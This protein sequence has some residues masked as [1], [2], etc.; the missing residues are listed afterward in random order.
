MLIC[1]V[2]LSCVSV[3]LMYYFSGKTETKAEYYFLADSNKILAVLT[4]I[5]AFVYFINLK[6]EYSKFINTVSMT[7]FGVLLIHANSDTMRKWLWKD[8]LN[9][10]GQYGSD[11]LYL[12]AILSVFAIFVV[13]SLIDFLRIK[14][15]EEPVFKIIN[16]KLSD[17]K[18][19]AEN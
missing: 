1:S 19:T 16:K 17:K 3:F 18:I 6:L 4:S 5:S 14:L 13:A 7:T 10:A 15:F 11:N 12:H 2:L 8:F 9:I